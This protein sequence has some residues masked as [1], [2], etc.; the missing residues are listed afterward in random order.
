MHMRFVK[1]GEKLALFHLSEIQ[2]ESASSEAQM[3]ERM[4]TQSKKIQRKP[5]RD[6]YKSLKLPIAGAFIAF[7]YSSA[8][9]CQEYISSHWQS[10]FRARLE[11]KIHTTNGHSEKLIDI[12][13]H[14]MDFSFLLLHL[15]LLPSFLQRLFVF[16]FFFFNKKASFCFIL[17]H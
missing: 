14:M 17:Y 9:N 10:H 11:N 15:L 3:R 6:N 7:H 5:I 16:F 12:L 2:C 13:F 8:A 1:E 4:Y